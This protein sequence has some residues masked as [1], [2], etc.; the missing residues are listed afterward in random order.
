ML[1]L[2]IRNGFKYLILQKKAINRLLQK[3]VYQS[4]FFS[5][6]PLKKHRN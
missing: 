3:Q 4:H 2:W 6:L 1:E 5:I